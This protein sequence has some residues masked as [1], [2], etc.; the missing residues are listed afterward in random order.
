MAA[1]PLHSKAVAAFQGRL[2]SRAAEI[3]GGWD[4]LR[5]RLG[6]DAHSLELWRDGSARI[7]ERIFLAVADV[8]L[9]DDIARAAQDSRAVPRDGGAALE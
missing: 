1:R 7:P 3:C 8:I 6:V 2:L 5:A 9:E 4:A